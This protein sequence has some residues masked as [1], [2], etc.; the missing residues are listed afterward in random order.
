MMQQVKKLKVEV[1]ELKHP[2]ESSR[3]S[4]APELYSS[5]TLNPFADV[6]N[7]S[8]CYNDL[9]LGIQKQAEELKEL[10]SQLAARSRCAPGGSS[11]SLENRGASGW[12]RYAS[13]EQHCVRYYVYRDDPEDFGLAIGRSTSLLHSGA[14]AE[15][16]LQAWAA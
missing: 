14:D 11:G 3:A 8:N 6:G 9:L 5:G 7:A 13:M 15:P 4:F 12:N 16:G 10:K 2:C 1:A